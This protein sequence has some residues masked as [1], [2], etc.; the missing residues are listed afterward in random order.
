VPQRDS[1]LFFYF[2]APTC[3]GEEERSA[4]KGSEVNL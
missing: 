4:E 2:P 1:P 3:N